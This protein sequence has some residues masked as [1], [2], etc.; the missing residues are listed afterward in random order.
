MELNKFEFDKPYSVGDPRAPRPN[1]PTF[2][3][4]QEAEDHAA[5]YSRDDLAAVWENETGEI[6][7]IAWEGVLYIKN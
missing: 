4:R 2:D 6:L 5:R 3:T 7:S 1:D